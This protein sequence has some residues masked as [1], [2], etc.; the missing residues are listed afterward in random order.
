MSAIARLLALLLSFWFVAA[1]AGAQQKVLIPERL[2]RTTTNDDKG[3]AQWSEWKAVKCQG[4]SGT[5]KVK[6]DVCTRFAD[7]AKNCPD[8][9]RTEARE[10]VCRM[11]AGTGELADP[12]LKAACPGC[13]GAA[14]L[15]CTICGGGGQ[16]RV[17]GDKNWSSCPGCR[18]DGAFKCGACNGSRLVEPAALKP[19]MKDASVKDLSKAIAVTDQ[20]LKDLAALTPTGGD[21]VRKDVKALVKTFDT[22]GAVFPPLKRLG[23]PFEDYMGKIYSGKQFQGSAENEAKTITMVKDAAEHYLKHQKRMLDLAHKRAEANAKL[24]P[25]GKAK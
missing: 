8:C 23:K 11:C 13:L 20:A 19:A 16:L 25:E 6:C 14:F 18:G 4:C 15:I 1:A 5:G 7:D 21:K 12:L 22:A 3:V 2:E 24:A 17:G 9:K 10:A